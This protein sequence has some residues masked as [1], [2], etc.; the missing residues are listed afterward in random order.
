[1]SNAAQVPEEKRQALSS[2]LPKEKETVAKI[3]AEEAEAQTVIKSQKLGRK[4]LVIFNEHKSIKET[5]VFFL[6]AHTG[7]N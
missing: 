6:M 2:A 7:M 5:C 1:M 3:K 4:R